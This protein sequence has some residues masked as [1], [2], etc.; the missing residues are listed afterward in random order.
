MRQ[1]HPPYRICPHFNP[2]Q[3][4]DYIANEED[5]FAS[6][7]LTKVHT[8][9][10]STTTTWPAWERVGIHRCVSHWLVPMGCRCVQ[11]RTDKETKE[12]TRHSM[13]LSTGAET[14]YHR[15]QNKA[16]LTQGKWVT[17]MKT[18][19]FCNF[20][21]FFVMNA[22]NDYNC[23]RV[24]LHPD[25]IDLK[26]INFVAILAE[27]RLTRLVRMMER[28]LSFKHWII[29]VS[30]RFI[31]RKP[32][33][34][35]LGPNCKLMRPW[36]LYNVLYAVLCLD[37][38]VYNLSVCLSV[39]IQSLSAFR[40]ICTYVWGAAKKRNWKSRESRKA[41][42]VALITHAVLQRYAEHKLY[43]HSRI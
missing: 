4:G 1:P 35:H 33:W 30:Q 40:H 36:R 17:S 43:C 3:K 42:A 41:L 21:H 10:N 25:F 7:M 39:Y 18:H 14:S 13:C 23:F 6:R 34:I 19:C 28:D 38:S 22:M 12:K 27:P 20:N 2:S 31:Q 26:I 32:S 29:E 37:I 8:M 16:L 24:Q 9:H 15:L 5:G 11:L